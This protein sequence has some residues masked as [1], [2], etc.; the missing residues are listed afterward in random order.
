MIDAEEPVAI[1]TAWLSAADVDLNIIKNYWNL[2][3]YL[4]HVSAHVLAVHFQF[5]DPPHSHTR[6]LA[7]LKA[8]NST[9]DYEPLVVLIFLGSLFVEFVQE[10]TLAI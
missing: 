5:V 9:I 7:Y 6:A 8:Q 4:I 2:Y 1:V 10:L 3:Y